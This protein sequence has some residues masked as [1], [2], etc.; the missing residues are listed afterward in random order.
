MFK[1]HT[2]GLRARLYY[3]QNFF[4]Y[5]FDMIFMF[6]LSTFYIPMVYNW[7]RMVILSQDEP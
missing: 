7:V 3:F 1:T 4:H 5:I 2:A 6:Y